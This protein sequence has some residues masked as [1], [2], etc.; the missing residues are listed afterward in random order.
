ME[1]LGNSDY[2]NQIEV[3]YQEMRESGVKINGQQFKHQ[4]IEMLHE[5]EFFTV[6]ARRLR[7]VS[8]QDQMSRLEKERWI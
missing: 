1:Y 3:L 2:I 5:F 4:Q 8:G 7:E 6:A